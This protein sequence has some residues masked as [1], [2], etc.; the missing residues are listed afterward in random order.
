ML[1]EPR[2][3]I[4]GEEYLTVYLPF[5]TEFALPN[6]G[7]GLHLADRGAKGALTL[8]MLALP[9]CCGGL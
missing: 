2:A 7:W 8:E 3:K 5:P 9:D 6:Q 4:R 1:F